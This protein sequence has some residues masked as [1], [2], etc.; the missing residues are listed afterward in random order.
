MGCNKSGYICPLVF[1]KGKVV[2]SLQTFHNSYNSRIFV[3]DHVESSIASA[4][5]RSISVGIFLNGE[6]RPNLSTL[7]GVHN[8]VNTR[9]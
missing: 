8:T 1:L 6:V 9:V 7:A 4:I 2:Y 5:N 3:Y